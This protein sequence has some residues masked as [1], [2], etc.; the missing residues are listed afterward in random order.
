MNGNKSHKIVFLNEPNQNDMW[1]TC[2]SIFFRYQN[3]LKAKKNPSEVTDKRHTHRP[4]ELRPGVV[5]ALTKLLTQKLLCALSLSLSLS[6]SLTASLY[7]QRLQII[8]IYIKKIYSHMRRHG[9]VDPGKYI[10]ISWSNFLLYFIECDSFC[11][12]CNAVMLQCRG[13]G[14][15]CMCAWHASSNEHKRWRICP[16]KVST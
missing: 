3:K 16:Q 14:M 6:L 12:Y 15:Q 10:V 8:H 4:V 1:E 13:F 11:R 7:C 5:T 9:I 2:P